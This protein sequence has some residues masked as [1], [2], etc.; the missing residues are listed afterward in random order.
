MP[1]MD[2]FLIPSESCRIGTPIILKGP[3]KIVV[4]QV[5]FPTSLFKDTLLTTCGTCTK[6]FPISP[7]EFLVPT[8]LKSYFS[9]PEICKLSLLQIWYR[10]NGM[11]T[12]HGSLLC[13]FRYYVYLHVWHLFSLWCLLFNVNY[14]SMAHLNKIRFGGKKIL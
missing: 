13:L 5:F 2:D 8:H 1:Q 10:I 11:L 7:V 3:S 6:N 9:Q 4:Y 12:L 14:S